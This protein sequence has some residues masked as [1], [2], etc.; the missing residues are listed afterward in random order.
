MHVRERKRTVKSFAVIW[1]YVSKWFC[2]VAGQVSYLARYMVVMRAR[3]RQEED[4]KYLAA[5]FVI[6]RF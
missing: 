5:M 6:L 2:I 1:S 4:R 3:S